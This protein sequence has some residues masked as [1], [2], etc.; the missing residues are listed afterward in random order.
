MKD[1]LP[2]LAG[3]LAGVLIALTISALLTLQGTP[4]L[5]LFALLPAI[6]GAIF[7]RVLQHRSDKL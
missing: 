7:E 3:A 1:Y 5:I 2:Y 4:Q 6:G